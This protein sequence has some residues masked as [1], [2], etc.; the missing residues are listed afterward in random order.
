[1]PLNPYDPTEVLAYLPYRFGYA[2]TQ[3]L[4]ALAILEPEPGRWELGLAARLDLVDLADPE[5]FALAVAGVASQMDQD[6]TAFS[7]TVVYSDAPLQQTRAGRGLA[8]TVLARWLSNFSY[9][10]AGAT[11]LVAPD[12]FGALQPC[13]T[14]TADEATT[15]YPTA[16]LDQTVIAA[17][18]VLAGQVLAGSREELACPRDCESLR[19]RTAARAAARERRAMAARSAVQRGRWR[20]RMMDSYGATLRSVSDDPEFMPEPTV[21]GR[22]AAALDDP[23]LRD[24]LAAWTLTGARL[25]PGSTAVLDAFEVVITGTGRQPATAHLNA[26][27]RVLTEMVR[28]CARGRAGYPLALLAWLAWWRGD[29]ARADVL[30]SQCLREDPGC[31]LAHLLR[32][33]LDG[34]IRPGWARPAAVVAP[35][36]D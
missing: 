22:L 29:G 1:M 31:R 10:D 11:W 30:L 8:G 24:A 32:D 17:H 7:L 14:A 3:S 26:A 27:A 23:E 13:E 21:L 18:M 35:V 5:L 36:R 4:V 6:P 34:G 12:H 28:H 9:A 2:P 20:S 15:Q 33:A 25:T 19:R 16:V